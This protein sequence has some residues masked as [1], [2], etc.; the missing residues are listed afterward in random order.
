MLQ[1]KHIRINIL[2]LAEVIEPSTN[3]LITRGRFVDLSAGGALLK[4]DK[5]IEK[6]HIYTFKF[7][8]KDRY[9]FSF[10]GVAS[11]IKEITAEQKWLAGI[12]FQC[13]PLEKEK[14]ERIVDNIRKGNFTELEKFGIY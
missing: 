14:L 3:E 4:S 5:P 8:I 9:K 13:T 11:H 1:R 6:N 2:L 12:Q 7:E 10:Y